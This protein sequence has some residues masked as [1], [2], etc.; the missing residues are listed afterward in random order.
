MQR[1][2]QSISKRYRSNQLVIGR[3]FICGRAVI[4]KKK[5]TVIGNEESQAGLKM[6]RVWKTYLE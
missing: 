1:Q 2:S 3:L 4:I 5:W 6:L